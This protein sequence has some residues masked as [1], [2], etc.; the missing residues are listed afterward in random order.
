MNASQILNMVFRQLLRRGV[1]A[2]INK[3]IAYASKRGKGGTSTDPEQARQ[4]QKLA[5]RARQA[6]RLTRRF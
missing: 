6:S 3:G 4:A 2:G 1:N 5:K